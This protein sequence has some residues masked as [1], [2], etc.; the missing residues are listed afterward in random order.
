MVTDLA[1]RG[2]PKLKAVSR[3]PTRNP[4]ICTTESQK[5]LGI[6]GNRCLLEVPGAESEE[7]VV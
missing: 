1:E 4:V 2:D 5:A 3:V 7:L 6:E